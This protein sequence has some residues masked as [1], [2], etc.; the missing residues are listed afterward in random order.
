MAIRALTEFEQ[1]TLDQ[2]IS[3]RAKNDSDIEKL[4]T[5]EKLKALAIEKV[6]LWQ[7]QRLALGLEPW[8]DK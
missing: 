6:A 8:S 4:S 5:C 1:V 7:K 3:Y 2:L